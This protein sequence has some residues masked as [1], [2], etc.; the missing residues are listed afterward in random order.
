MKY[1]TYAEVAEMFKINVKTLRNWAS[2]GRLRTVKIFGSPR[3]TD[4][5]IARV[6]EVSNQKEEK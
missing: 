4:E 3:I 6:L 5:E 2:E 1:Y